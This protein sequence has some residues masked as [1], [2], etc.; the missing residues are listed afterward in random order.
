LEVKKESDCEDQQTKMFFHIPMERVISLEPRYLG[1]NYANVLKSRVHQEVEG[2]CSGRHGFII[3]VTA[4]D[5]FDRGKVQEGTGYVQFKVYF[6]AIVFRPFKG[7]VLDAIVTEVSK[8]GFFASAGPLTIFV[9]TSMIP[10]EMR[11]E[12]NSFTSEEGVK[13]EKDSEVR[14]RIIGIRIDATEI[15]GVGSIKDDYLGV[16][17]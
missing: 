16:L 9:S 2:T 10:P 15:V 14:L 7:E 1:P 4:I 6:R 11:F 13:I 5:R 8:M 17:S 3:Y 12:Q